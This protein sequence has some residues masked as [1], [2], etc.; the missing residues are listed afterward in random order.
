MSEMTT[1]ERMKRM[2]AHQ[3]ADRI[4]IVDVLWNSTR[5]RWEQQGMPAGVDMSDYFDIDHIPKIE[6][7]NSFRFEEKIL[8][9]TDEYIISTTVW[10]ATFKNWKHKGSTPGC[11][12]YSI[13]TADKWYEAK[14]RMVP[15][16]DRIPWD[17]LKANYRSWK[18]KGYWIRG[19]L[20]FGFDVAQSFAVGS[21]RFLI[22]LIEEPEWCVDMFNHYLDVSLALQ[23]M[24]WDAGY[25]FDEL[26]WDDDLAYKLTQ[27]FS[28]NTYRELLKPV[29]KRAIEWAQQKGIKTH[30]HSCG[31]ITP[32][33][34]ELIDIGLDAVNPLEVKSGI[35]PIEL[36]KKY[37]RDILFRG[38]NNAMLWDSFEQT[39]AEMRKIVPAMKESGGY[40]FSS[41]HSIPDSVKL[42]TYRKIVRL[43]KELGSYS[44]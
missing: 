44:C 39:E 27:F 30:M 34:P 41:D 10:G 23:Q 15:T 32:F 17:Y 31:E 36:K 2:Y 42:D 26:S 38:G 24:V 33:I 40:I 29:H 43:A 35:N 19:R 22:A 5:E 9:E 13:K 28:V 25:E 3:E 16:P 6:V 21:E 8:E 1:H 7:D 14:K 12:D 37:G 18:E 4:P 20:C 11:L